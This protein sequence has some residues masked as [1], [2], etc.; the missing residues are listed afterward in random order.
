MPVLFADGP[1][2]IEFTFLFHAGAAPARA[3]ASHPRHDLGARDHTRCGPHGY[4][5]DDQMFPD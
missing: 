5:C 2:M 3:G 4:W 1:R